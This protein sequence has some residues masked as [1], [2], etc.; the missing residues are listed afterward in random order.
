[1]LPLSL[2][3][4]LLFV[5]FVFFVA[6]WLQCVLSV[7]LRAPHF[8]GAQSAVQPLQTPPSCRAFVLGFSDGFLSF[9]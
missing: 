6:D 4:C 2:I 8:P 1:M 3:A 7:M 5:F 9:N